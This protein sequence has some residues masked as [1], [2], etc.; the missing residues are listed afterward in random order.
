M[1]GEKFQKHQL[2]ELEHFPTSEF[3]VKFSTEKP[4]HKTYCKENITREKISLDLTQEPFGNADF[5]KIFKELKE[6]SDYVLFVGQPK[7]GK[8]L[9]VKEFARFLTKKNHFDFI[10]FCNVRFKIILKKLIFWIYY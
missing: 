4:Q 3:Q 2:N 10:F 9:L 6:C 7:V 5:D 8:S 1:E